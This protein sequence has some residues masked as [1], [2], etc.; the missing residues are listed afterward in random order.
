MPEA[1]AESTGGPE[2][3]DAAPV[4]SGIAGRGDAGLAGCASP[5]A[6]CV[7]LDGTLVAT[8]LLWEGL[9][10]LVRERPLMLRRV[11]FW[12][13]A[14]KAHFKQQVANSADIDVATL[15]YRKDLIDFLLRE[16]DRGRDLVLATAADAKH[17]DAVARHLGLFS[18]VLSSDGTTNLSGQLKCDALRRRFGA[19]GFDYAGN[20]FVDL[21]MWTA[22]GSAVLVAT[23]ARLAPRVRAVTNV[24]AEFASGGSRL[25]AL[26]QALRPHQWVKNILIFVPVLLDHRLTDGDVLLRAAVAFIAFSLAASGGYVVNDLLDVQADR[27]HPRKQHRPFAAGTLSLRTGVALAPLLFAAAI[28]LAVLALPPAFL[29][30]LALYIVLTGGY[31]LY[32]KRFP[33]VDVLLLAGL[34]TLRVL[35]GIAATGVRFSTWLLAFSMFLFLSL[36]FV[37]RY[38][39]LSRRRT[40]EGERVAGRGYV[41]ADL[42]WLGSMGGASGYLSVLVLALYISSDEVTALYERPMVLWMICPLLLFWVSRLWFFAHRGKIDEDPILETMSDR[43]SYIVGGFVALILFL[44]L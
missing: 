31:S 25:R 15:P 17:A 34:Y 37:K 11:P 24:E 9:L 18:A 29:A 39:E 3:G 40:A 21:P 4:A 12:L 2:R 7:D 22:A 27:R 5:R 42:E 1:S 6:L 44:A 16:R 30:L 8:D 19:T 43:L 20:D 36:A 35:A 14:G 38:A 13:L 32:L 23:P 41:N 26:L 28:L 10:A 33:V